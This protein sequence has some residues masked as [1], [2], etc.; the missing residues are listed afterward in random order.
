VGCVTVGAARWETR[1]AAE[2]GAASAWAP[3]TMAGRGLE[4]QHA[5]EY[6]PEIQLSQHMQAAGVWTCTASM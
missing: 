1:P 4:D 2:P 3:V 6:T 5:L